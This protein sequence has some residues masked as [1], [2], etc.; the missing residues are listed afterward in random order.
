MASTPANTPGPMIVTS[1]SAHRS[2]LI[3]R[4]ETMMKSATGRTKTA[5]GVVLR[6]ARNAIGNA[7]TTAINVPSVAILMVS[8]M[9]SQSW[10]M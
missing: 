1:I 2:E 10:S 8:Q 4:D 7:R 5:D 3:D 9:A 6:A